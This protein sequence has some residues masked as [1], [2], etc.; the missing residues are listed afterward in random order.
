MLG[1]VKSILLFAL[2]LLASGQSAFA[3]FKNSASD[4]LF[5]S[6]EAACLSR[7]QNLNPTYQFRNLAILPVGSLKGRYR[8]TYEY[9]KESAPN[10]W[11]R[12]EMSGITEVSQCTV[13]EVQSFKGAISS[14][15]FT[16]KEQKYFVLGSAPASGC[17]S[18]CTYES[19]VSKTDSCYLLKGSTTQGYCNYSLVNSGQ[20]C[21]ANTLSPA[22]LSGDSLTPPV[23]DPG[24]G[25]P[26]PGTG[27]PGTDPGTGTPGTDPGTGTPGTDP[28]TGTPGTD[29]GTGT[30]GTDPGTGTPGT[31]PGTD[32]GTGNPGTGPGTGTGSGEGDKYGAVGSAEYSRAQDLN[33][34]NSGISKGV[35]Q[36]QDSLGDAA[37]KAL[38]D[39]GKESKDAERSVSD[40]FKSFLP[41]SSACINP[42]LRLLSWLSI[43]IDI[44][45]YIFV[46]TLLSW[47]FS[48]S[49]LFYVFRVLT[50]LGSTT[51]EV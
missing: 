10:T 13:G 48:V 9:S 19:K 29:P 21:S 30:P 51:S 25:T 24:T 7:I 17:Y 6:A 50:S 41:S 20:S 39:A 16:E 2:V 40:R 43:T 35:D 47:V 3:A 11:L 33:A 34:A 36:A 5:P 15:I 37:N 18:S 42:Q 26:D 31:D 8:C 28:G 12:N 14:V 23:T 44:C 46:K 32:P 22:D 45:R 38:N 1:R 4:E 27:T 49:T